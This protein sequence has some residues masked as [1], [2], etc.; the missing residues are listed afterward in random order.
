MAIDEIIDEF[1]KAP[2][3]RLLLPFL[4]GIILEIH[5]N[6]SAR[7]LSIIGY[8]AFFLLLIGVF[9]SIKS[10]FF[11][12]TWLL[13]IGINAIILLIGIWITF[14]FF[15]QID[16]Q[17]Q[18]LKSEKIILL[19]DEPFV[20][21]SR[22][23][24]APLCVLNFKNNYWQKTKSHIMTYLSVDSATEKL[25]LGDVLYVESKPFEIEAPSNPFA[26]DYRNYLYYNGICGQV[27]IKAGQWHKIKNINN[28]KI[29]LYRFR[30][31]LLDLYKQSVKNTN[32]YGV[33][34]ALV[35]GYTG[36]LT[37]EVKNAYASTGAMHVLSVSGLHVGIVYIF[38]M[39][40]FSFIGGRLSLKI[41]KVLLLLT[42]VWFYAMLTGMSPPVIRS[43]AMCSFF[44][45][46]SLANRPANSLNILAASAFFILLINPF[47][48]H[49]VGFQLSFIAV[50]SILLFNNKIYNIFS[51]YSLI[52]NKLWMCISVSLAA[53]LGTFPLSLYYFHQFPNYFLLTNI[54]VIPLTTI[55]LYAGIIFLAV[56]SWKILF[57]IT[58][59]ILA[60][61]LKLL[62]NI[63]FF[64]DKL[65]FSVTGN[66]YISTTEMICIYGFIL[67]LF[68]FLAYKENIYLLLS[69]S[70][71][72][73]FI[74]CNGIE[75]T[76]RQLQSKLV[77]YKIKDHS[78]IDIIKGKNHFMILD[79]SLKTTGN[80]L[81]QAA[82]NFWIRSGLTHNST[83]NNIK[84]E[85]LKGKNIA[86]Y[87]NGNTIVLLRD[88]RIFN[89]ECS[90]PLKTDFLVISGN[91][92][93]FAKK[94]L[95]YFT[96]EEIILDSSLNKDRLKYLN[97][98]FEKTGIRCYPV[99]I[100]GAFVK[101][102]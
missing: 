73:F 15:K 40:I 61:M 24:K 87:L 79:D 6:F 22:W 34:S 102:L 66:I 13:G 99:S 38:L 96:P 70:C 27:F 85:Y 98:E 90:I 77:V 60:I 82:R 20:E 46:A 5:L 67:C 26:F 14:N 28:L 29:K 69:L 33:L 52:I 57:V 36:D 101:D 78:A 43:A 19:I 62:N 56:T 74:L 63:I 45:I 72:C 37:N 83:L 65:P 11:H 23:F 89:F 16:R 1:K 97:K 68:V 9:F 91:I 64:I 95:N 58:S 18:V 32:D 25:K 86:I 81:K 4:A 51:P 59:P 47:Q 49:D 17:K 48:L 41:L 53:Q 42:G 92:N 88:E 21:N 44:T 7:C 84:I 35:L 3:L 93:C 39:W 54:L 30:E 71:L 76:G 94:I 12:Y 55:I 50:L 2:F 8:I 75:E 31:K 80:E 100:Y 10:Y